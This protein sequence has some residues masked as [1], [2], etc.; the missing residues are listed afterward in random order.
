MIDPRGHAIKKKVHKVIA[1]PQHGVPV[2]ISRQI[3]GLFHLTPQQVMR[4]K[5]FSQLQFNLLD[6]LELLEED[7]F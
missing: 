4:Q 2:A 6:A 7:F 3:K 1:R 5:A